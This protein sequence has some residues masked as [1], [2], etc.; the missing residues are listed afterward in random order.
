MIRKIAREPAVA[1]SM[2]RSGR[3]PAAVALALGLIGAT[4]VL[5][6]SL[7]RIK[8]TD[9]TI[10]VTG[11]AKR[12]IKSDLVTWTAEVSA[13]HKDRAAAYKEVAANVPK[14]VAWLQQKGVRADQIKVESISTTQQHPR[15]KEG[16]VIE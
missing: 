13:T 6:R 2:E 1:C 11:S 8:D 7:V 5:G 3:F 14:V 9:H 12:R 10:S 4:V 15:D 16:Q